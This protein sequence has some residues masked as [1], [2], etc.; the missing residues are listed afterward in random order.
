MLSKQW[1]HK[2][3]QVLMISYM[4]S[5]TEQLEGSKCWWRQHITGIYVVYSRCI[6]IIGVQVQDDIPIYT[7]V[8]KMC[9]FLMFDSGPGHYITPC[10]C[11]VTRSMRMVAL[12]TQEL[13]IITGM[14]MAREHT[15]A[16]KFKFCQSRWAC[17][18]GCVITYHTSMQVTVTV[19]VTVCHDTL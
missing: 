3:Y 17:Q 11:T 1:Y 10:Q 13:C 18:W 12:Q 14:M 6:P 15:K 8:A 2:W 5:Y 16:L 4:M 9:P 7:E 19:T